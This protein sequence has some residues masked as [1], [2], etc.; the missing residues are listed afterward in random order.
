L[1]VAAIAVPLSVL[2]ASCA[3]FAVAQLPARAA[4]LAIGASFSRA[5]GA[6]LLYWWAFRRVPADVLDAARVDGSG[7]FS[8]WAR[9]AMPL[10]WPVTLAV[11][12]LAFVVSWAN[13]LDPLI[14]LYDA[15]RFTLPL[16]LR[17]LSVLGREHL[18]LLL[19][20][21]VVATAPVVLVLAPLHRVL[22]RM[23]VKSIAAV[24]LAALSLVAASCGGGDEEAGSGPVRFLVFGDPEELKAYREVA[25]AFERKQA[26]ADVR[27][28]EAS[29]RDD[30]L[31]RLATSFSGGDPPDAFLLSYRF[32]GQFAAKGRLEPVEERLAD[33][34]AFE[35][36]DFYPQALDAF[37]FGGRLTCLPQNISSL[38]VYYNK[39]LLRKAGVALPGAGWTWKEFVDTAV[40]LTDPDA[41]RYGL[42]VEPS[43]IRIAPFVWSNGGEL[44]KDDLS[45]FA[46][47]S[48]EARE[49]LEQFML[50]RTAYQVIPA[51][52]E[53][54]A[55]DDEARFLNG[56]TAMVLSS[57]RSTPS[58]RT[59]T[60]FDWDVAPL[61]RFK[62]AAG[63]LHSDAYCL[64]KGAANTEGAWQ[65]M[66][67]ALGPEGQRITARAGRTVP[68]LMSVAESDA[69]LDP[70]AKP[71]SSRVFLDT[72][73]VIRRVPTIA[74]WPEIEDAAGPVL[75]EALYEGATP[76]EVVRELDAATRS[77][78]KRAQS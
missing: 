10:V 36:D 55:E 8:V 38:V 23:V 33:S 60:A 52:E 66:E 39:D 76:G 50:L 37:R 7:P 14:Y 64:P 57:R 20:G 4:R 45:G 75:E 16:G 35:E 71:A 77:I 1:L 22:R 49:P 48:P 68:S 58:F 47:G 65:F 72:I 9:V 63:I 19:A 67:F 40:E 25:A 27:I 30:L 32:Y 53:V 6:V 5:D 44:V 74:E 42:G 3:G 26:D 70:S 18:P 43:L 34:D 46:L 31:A 59:I 41:G 21:A 12:A 29:D 11:A 51:E 54:E 28:V 61:P 13:F 73:P 78:W 69:F 15:E 24:V 2:V 17:S 56:R 62:Q